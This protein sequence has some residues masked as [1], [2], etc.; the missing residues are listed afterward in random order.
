MTTI[1]DIAKIAGVSKA[2]VSRVIN[3][4]PGVSVATRQKIKQIIQDLD[5]HPNQVARSL[6]TKKSK[7][8]GIIIPNIEN[9]FYSKVIA[10]MEKILT[11]AGYQL[12]L[13]VNTGQD[14]SKYLKALR[15]LQQNNVDGIISSAFNL[16]INKLHLNTPLIIFDS[17]DIK[18]SI[19]RIVSNNVKGGQLLGQEIVKLGLKKIV[20]QHGPLSLP[21]LKER[22]DSLVSFLNV[23]H[24]SY[25]L[26][27]ITGFLNP[28]QECYEL[29]QQ[30]IN[31]DGVVAFN[32]IY[33][34]QVL[35]QAIQHQVNVPTDLKIF[36]YDNIDFSEFW[37][38]TT[39]DQQASL[40]GQ[41]AANRLLKVIS[42]PQ[43][44]HGD[45]QI[46]DVKLIERKS[47]QSK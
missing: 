34:S 26:Q 2:S 20:I 29:F 17:A 45:N 27:E 9:P 4:E 5:Y 11:K 31:F 3:N 14:D 13:S 19:P 28:S 23:N 8:V 7:L 10:G 32:D 42:K 46:I 44:S 1:N 15:N 35:Y 43:E 33:A 18:D 16:D 12:I 39:I 36:G 24:V 25:Q 38:I 6:Y 22:F 41:T 21:T 37:G 30:E 40:I 47:T